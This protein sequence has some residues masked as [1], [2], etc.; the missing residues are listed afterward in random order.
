MDCLLL[1]LAIIAAETNS[2]N[3]TNI[4][5]L[6][7]ECMQAGFSCAAVNMKIFRQ[8]CFRNMDLNF[9]VQ[10]KLFGTCEGRT[11]CTGPL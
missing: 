9:S 8:I 11:Q 4:S 5:V 2:N 1:S 6:C 7:R 10:T 3:N